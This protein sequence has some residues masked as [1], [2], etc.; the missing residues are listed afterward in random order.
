MTINHIKTY[1]EQVRWQTAKSKDHQYTLKKWKPEMAETFEN[2]VMYIRNFGYK[3]KF[4]GKIYIYLTV[5]NY[6]YWTMGN[7]L[8]ETILINRK[9]SISE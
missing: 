9:V 8:D 2:F 5:D 3:E 1:I 6:T 4:Y 7:P